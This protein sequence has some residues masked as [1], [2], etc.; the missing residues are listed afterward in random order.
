[1]H[2]MQASLNPQSN[3]KAGLHHCD[4]NEVGGVKRKIKGLEPH[5]RYPMILIPGGMYLASRLSH[6]A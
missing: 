3:P 1:M 2:S 6:P 5:C 4:H